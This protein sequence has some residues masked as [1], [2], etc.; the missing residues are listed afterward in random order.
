MQTVHHENG[1]DEMRAMI[2]TAVDN[3][4]KKFS[5]WMATVAL[6]YIAIVLGVILYTL[7][8]YRA[9]GA[10]A[11]KKYEA[12][13]TRFADEYI[14]QQEAKAI[15]MPPDPKELLLDQQSEALAKVLYGVKDNSANDL[16]T[17][18]WCVFNRVDNPAYP[19]TLEDVIAQKKQWM[20]YYES[21]PVLDDLYKIAREQIQLWQNGRR[22][23]S[24]EFVYMSWTA[25]RIVLRDSWQYGMN[26][27]TWVWSGDV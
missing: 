23:V 20:G 15:G 19:E 17:L 2:L 26:T 7:V 18:C 14:T 21:N 11:D 13:K 9:G 10:Q 25:A 3:Y 6:K 1:G 8:V 27:N 5:W 22:P 12:W 16:R 4:H 24:N